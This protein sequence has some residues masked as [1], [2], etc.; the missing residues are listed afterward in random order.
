MNSATQNTG[1]SKMNTVTHSEIKNEIC[2][3]TPRFV[4]AKVAGRF[5]QF[6][7]RSNGQ[8]IEK[9]KK[10]GLGLELVWS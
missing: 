1:A 4:V 6:T 8:W 7:I 10:I 9:G 3:Q 2:A 5:V